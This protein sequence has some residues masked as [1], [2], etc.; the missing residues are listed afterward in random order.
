MFIFFFKYQFL[1]VY[2]R[3]LKKDEHM[4]QGS[5]ASII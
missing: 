1:H 3:E 4:T 5:Y 2:I